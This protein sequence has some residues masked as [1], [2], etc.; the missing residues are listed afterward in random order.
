MGKGRLDRQSFL[1][2]HLVCRIVEPVWIRYC[3]VDYLQVFADCKITKLYK[4]K[5]NGKE[6]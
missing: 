4:E 1:A 3:D 6:D 5:Q 2:E